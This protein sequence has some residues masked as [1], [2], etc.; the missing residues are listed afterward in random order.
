[1]IIYY[2]IIAEAFFEITNAHK[3]TDAVIFFPIIRG[4]IYSILQVAI[5]AGMPIII[6]YT[7]RPPGK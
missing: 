4:N 1:M 5:N 2:I 7:T 3:I 6:D